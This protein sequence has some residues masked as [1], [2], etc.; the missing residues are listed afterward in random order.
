ML[1]SFLSNR[2]PGKKEEMHEEVSMHQ[3][4]LKIPK[5]ERKESDAVD[6]HCQSPSHIGEN[7]SDM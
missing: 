1:K 3:Q 2:T 5:S 4:D 7:V 6:I